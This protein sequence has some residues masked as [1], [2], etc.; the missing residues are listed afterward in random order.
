MSRLGQKHANYEKN[1]QSESYHASC[2][3]LIGSHPARGHRAHAMIA[4]DCMRSEKRPARPENPRA[5]GQ[6]S[7]KELRSLVEKAGIVLGPTPHVDPKTEAPEEVV[8]PESDEE[9]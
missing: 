9:L 5:R 3:G 7:L 1:A 6:G 4:T 8:V 2:S